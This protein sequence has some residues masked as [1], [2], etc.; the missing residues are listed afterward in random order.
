MR[1]DDDLGGGRKNTTYT[2]DCPINLR[3]FGKG[4]T[5]VV[6]LWGLD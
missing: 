6:M 1:H 5:R 2:R 3:Q 4:M